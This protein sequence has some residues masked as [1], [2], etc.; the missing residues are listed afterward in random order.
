MSRDEG[1]EEIRWLTLLNL[2]V[3]LSGDIKLTMRQRYHRENVEGVLLGHR[4][5]YLRR[6]RQRI[7]DGAEQSD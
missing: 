1:A 7:A 6:M 2:R 3:Y 5:I 4:P